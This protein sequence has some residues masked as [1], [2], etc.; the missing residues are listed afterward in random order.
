MRQR[1]EIPLSRPILGGPAGRRLG[2]VRAVALPCRLVSSP[3]LA[4]GRGKPAGSR[5]G[6]AAAAREMA[7]LFPTPVLKFLCFSPW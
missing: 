1:S 6:G 5:F 4:G 7:F 2:T 3:L